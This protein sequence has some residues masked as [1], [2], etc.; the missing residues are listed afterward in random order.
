MQYKRADMETNP[1]R[2]FYCPSASVAK[3]AGFFYAYKYIFKK[4]VSQQKFLK[5]ILF[6]NN[7]HIFI[8]NCR[9]KCFLMLQSNQ[10]RAFKINFG[11]FYEN[12]GTEGKFQNEL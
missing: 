3:S 12:F 9:K 10:H 1:Y 5:N 2:L 6:Y 4:R 8:K 7:F 11:G